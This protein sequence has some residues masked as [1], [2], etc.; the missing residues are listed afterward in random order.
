MHSNS[1]PLLLAIDNGTQSLRALLFSADGTLLHMAQLPLAAYSSPEPGWAEHEPEYYW[2]TLCQACQQL[3]VSSG[4]DKARIQGVAVTTQRGTVVNLDAQGRPLRPAIL[5]MDRRRTA[6]LKAPGGVLGLGLRLGGAMST[7]VHFQ[8]EA[9][10]NWIRSQQPVLWAK[11]AKFLLLS[12]WLN[13]RLSGD[14][15]DSSAS[16]VGYLP[17]DFKHKRWAKVGNWRWRLLDLTPEQMPQLFAPGTVMA[18]IS[19]AASEATG[20]PHGLPL[21]AAAADKACEVLG[22]GGISPAIA[23]LSF[24]TAATVNIALPDYRE[25]LR[26]VPAYPAAHPAMYNLEL[27]IYRGFW[28]VSWFK[29]Q[30]GH[31]EQSRGAALGVSAETLFDELV[32]AVAPGA[33]GLIL[34]PYWTPGLRS[35]GPEGRGAVIGFSDVHTRAHLYRAILEGLAYGL[36]EGMECLVKR[37][38]TPA[39]ELRVSGGGSISSAAMQITADI[40]GLP[41]HRPHTLETAGLGAAMTIAVAL[42]IHADFASASRAMTRIGASFQPDPAAQALYQQ[43]YTRVYKPLYARLKPLYDAIGTITQ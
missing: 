27:Q 22:A 29:E 3:W 1:E 39:T 6:G 5:W 10:A 32:G 18:T 8:A 30:F 31:L 38:G 25:P 36:R 21:I 11:T 26:F 42:G 16:Q 17:F 19:R 40:F 4:V 2:Q 34:Q 13:Y 9:E 33:Q 43:L 14:Y 24:G 35:P 23:C 20:I 41:A 12:G 37:S 28:M 15:V 7:L